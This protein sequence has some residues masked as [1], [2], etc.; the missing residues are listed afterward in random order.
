MIIIVIIIPLSFL[1]LVP[2]DRFTNRNV[3]CEF[4]R[5]SSGLEK[6]INNELHLYGCSLYT[7]YLPYKHVSVCVY[8]FK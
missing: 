2:D 8:I 5:P 1:S 3:I 4:D 6:Y 7:Y